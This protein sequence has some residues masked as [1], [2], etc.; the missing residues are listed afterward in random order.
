MLQLDLPTYEVKL[1]STGKK[2]KIR[3]FTV[4]EEKLL[5]IA[6]ESN[7]E[8]D[9][10][11]TTKQVIKNCIVSEPLDLEKLPFFDVD[12]LFI[13][14]RAKSVGDNV[15]VKF[16]CEA[17][18]N[19]TKCAAVFPVKIDISNAKIKKDD[20]I[21]MDIPIS[22]KYTIKMKYP[23]YTDVKSVLDNESI[24]DK[25]VSLVASSIAYIVDGDNVHKASEMTRS[26]LLQFVEG[27]TNE[28]FRKLEYFVDN[29]PTF[30][31]EADAQCPNCGFQHH[32]EYKDF[33]SFFV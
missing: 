30:V 8:K 10:I 31:V 28:Q 5:L 6:L 2:V 4:K 16:R 29:Y 9:I 21:K 27:L 12:Y 22:G 23:S 7:E 13:A 19:G 18:Y 25:K 33:T 32:I 14:L 26:A 20:D 11:E 1:P 24:L 15:D 3:P 17:A